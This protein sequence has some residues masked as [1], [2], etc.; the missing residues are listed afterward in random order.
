MEKENKPAIIRINQEFLKDAKDVRYELSDGTWTKYK[1][2][3]DSEYAVARTIECKNSKEILFVMDID[4][5][6]KSMFPIVLKYL[7]KRLK[8]YKEQTGITFNF[9]FSGNKG[10]H[11]MAKF[12]FPFKHELCYKYLKDYAYYWWLKNDLKPIGIGFGEQIKN[13]RVQNKKYTAILDTSLFHRNSLIR[14]FCTRFNGYYCVPIS[15]DDTME[16]V[17]R[18]S[19]LELPLIYE[20]PN[21][22]ITTK[23]FLEYI[24][25]VGT[26]TQKRIK[27][28]NNFNINVENVLADP[29]ASHS[30]R[31]R[32][33][34]NL[35]LNGMSAEEILNK[36]MSE[37]QWSDLDFNKTK[38]QVFY[39]IEWVRRYI[40]PKNI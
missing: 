14:G 15:F 32:L 7:E 9:S 27:K 37:S 22:Y 5:Y 12:I 20:M 38:Y 34:A 23:D 16:T 25:K 40:E 10:F 19:K 24:N 30:Q 35:Y 17:L 1:P 11:I 3:Y 33:V 39:T 21:V 31:W 26:K 36:I 2:L 13:N 4:L 8:E 29:D 6:D 18:K 28:K